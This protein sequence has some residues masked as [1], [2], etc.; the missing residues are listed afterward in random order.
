[1]GVTLGSGQVAQHPNPRGAAQ[2]HKFL[3][4]LRFRAS[5]S[6]AQSSRNVT[7]QSLRHH[8]SPQLGSM[9]ILSLKTEATSVSNSR[10]LKSGPSRASA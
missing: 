1:M 4:G 7:R 5:A 10:S 9:V 6:T 3:G 8:Q 2:H